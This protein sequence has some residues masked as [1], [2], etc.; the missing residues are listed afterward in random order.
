MDIPVLYR[1]QNL[2][3][4]YNDPVNVKFRNNSTYAFYSR[5]LLKRAISAFDFTIPDE[6]SKTYFE[7]TLFCRGFGAV[8][9]YEKIG[10]IFQGGTL[11][12]RDI[13][14]QPKRFQLANPAL[15]SESLPIYGASLN[16]KCVLIKLQ[17]DYSPITD[18]VDIF[19]IRIALAYEAWT[20]NTQNS[21]LSYVGFFDNKALA[22][23]FSELF[24]RIQSGEPA[25]ATGRGLFDDNGK[26]RWATFA[27]DLKG[28]YI[29]PAISDDIRNLLNE[30]NS[31]IGIPNNPESRKKERSIVDEV[32]AN[33]VETDTL[34][35]Q[36]TRTIKE[37]FDAANEFYGDRLSVKL[38]VKKR[39]PV[40]DQ[41]GESIEN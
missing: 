37:G 13:Y 1:A 18:I 23:S 20:M 35:D 40:Y 19:A 31:F 30:F 25:T 14:Y 17:P 33:N 39:Y 38:D 29:A 26:P 15:K 27:Q 2:A 34:I 28:N 22:K 10:V 41:G 3:S 8:L 4:A 12:G 5:Y 24:D 7:Y 36:M 21:K 11:Y 16:P 32:N 9:D 6:W